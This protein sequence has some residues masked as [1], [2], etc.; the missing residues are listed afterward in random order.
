MNNRPTLAAGM[1]VFLRLS[2]ESMSHAAAITWEQPHNISGSADVITTGELVGAFN[3]GAAGIPSTVVNSVMFSP[4]EVPVGG[5][6]PTLVSIGIFTF[7]GGPFQANN[8]G[9]GSA[10]APFSTLASSDPAYA[11][12]LQSGSTTIN[13]QSL[14][15]NGLSIGRKYLIQVWT[16]DSSSAFWTGTLGIHTN[17]GG[18]YVLLDT[19]TADAAG[20]LGQFATG[21]FVA[22][23]SYQDFVFTPGVPPINAFQL[24]DLSGVP[25]PSFWQIC[26]FVSVVVIGRRSLPRRAF[27]FGVDGRGLGRRLAGK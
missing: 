14:Q 25:E 8:A 22:N 5:F 6:R 3:V 24:R 26:G 16:N 19:N 27:T 10:S 15:L 4:L 20:G 12:L 21:I 13:A 23:S 18:E 11:Q 1:A 7:G 17:S 9:F 2:L